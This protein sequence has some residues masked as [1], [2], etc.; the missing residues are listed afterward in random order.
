MES[1]PPRESQTHR[2]LEQLRKLAKD[3]KRDLSQGSLG[4]A[5][6]IQRAVPTRASDT[7]D[8]IIQDGVRLSESQ[9]V[10]ARESGFESWPKMQRAVSPD[11]M[12]LDE[13]ARLVTNAAVSG[14]VEQVRESLRRE[15]GLV[16]SHLAVSLLCFES[17]ALSRIGPDAI[18]T[19]IA[20]ND[21]PPIMYVLCS[22]FATDDAARQAR[23]DLVSALID[24]GADVNAG[25]AELE[26]PRGFRTA[27]GAAVGLARDPEIVRALLD[28][29]ADIN[30]GPTLY[31]GS[32]MWEA[33]RHQDADS[34]AL[35]LAAD[36]PLW[37][38]CHALPHALQFES[39][40]MEIPD[41]RRA[42]RA[43]SLRDDGVS[44]SGTPESRLS[45]LLLDHGADPDWNKVAWG[46]EGSSVAEAVV[47]D[48]SAAT[49]G[50]L[51]NS[52]ANLEFADRAGRT[53]LQIAVSLHREPLIALLRSGGADESRVRDLDRALGRCFAGAAMDDIGGFEGVNAV[54]HVW[55]CRA[56]R[57]SDEAT[58]LRLLEAG[59]CPD[60]TDD[61]GMTAL[62]LAVQLKSLDL[63]RRLLDAGANPNA[64]NYAGETALDV[65]LGIPANDELLA[66]L[67]GYGVR[68]A[69]PVAGLD[70]AFE[71]AADAVVDGNVEQ[72]RTLLAGYPELVRARS[73]R[74]HRCTLLHYLG[75][76]GVENERQKT[77][78][79][80]VEVIE[81]LLQAGCDPDALCYTYRGGPG[82]STFGLMISS[83]HPRDAGLT[84]AMAAALVN[85][86]AKEGATI[87]STWRFLLECNQRVQSGR[88]PSISDPR[89]A[90]HGL[91][92]AAMLG[93][94]ELVVALI[95]AGADVNA[96][97]AGNTTALHQAAIGGDD[98]MVDLLLSRG[99]DPLIRDAT[100]NGTASGW[101]YAGGHTD[102][103]QRLA[104]LEDVDNERG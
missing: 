77:P 76:N 37:H 41:A 75:A 15:P 42:I 58:A 80:A 64:L 18:N 22:R 56:I 65:A 32:A 11:E 61:D 45:E 90:G 82:Q 86:G 3:L 33:V 83:S 12:S 55:L 30:D 35:L 92:E 50:R 62:H 2:N 24:R 43:S 104:S 36:P 34:L 31:E 6:R 29:G 39:A 103:G 84:L 70:E 95:D 54:D 25:V 46:F 26:S 20:P 53:P 8:R 17:G 73:S 4:A 72:L 89:L 23:R 94:S 99:A 68:G 98:E 91:I 87:D 14:N 96:C 27:L 93:E 49:L 69:L 57:S 52:G 1:I 7:L 101:A 67:Q 66:S 51:I 21:W 102:L 13:R 81:C 85:G 19:P 88:P 16:G 48:V 28:A 10:I 38:K 78:A 74:P 9:F 40:A 59:L 79:N 63:C 60:A 97:N 5:A 44:N 71:M 100:F 47:L